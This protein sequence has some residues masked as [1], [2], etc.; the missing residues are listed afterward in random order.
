[1]VFGVGFWFCWARAQ[2]AL[3]STATAIKVTDFIVATPYTTAT[4]SANVAVAKVV[5]L[6]SASVDKDNAIYHVEDES[7]RIASNI[8]KLPDWWDL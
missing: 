4:S 7:S 6:E 8:A 2:L 3:S 5:P 1:M